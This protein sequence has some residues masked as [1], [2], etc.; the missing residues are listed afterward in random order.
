M[1][2]LLYSF[3]RVHPICFPNHR[4]LIYDL[5]AVKCSYFE[6]N[7]LT[8]YFDHTSHMSLNRINLSVL[9]PAAKKKILLTN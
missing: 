4:N 8:N 7:G 3:N 2:M 9:Q 6:I 5:L 1:K